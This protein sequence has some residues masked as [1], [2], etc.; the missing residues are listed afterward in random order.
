VVVKIPTQIELHE[1]KFPWVAR[2]PIL[3][4]TIDRCITYLAIL[5]IDSFDCLTDHL[6]L[7]LI[8][9]VILRATPIACLQKL[10]GCVHARD[11]METKFFAS[12]SNCIVYLKTFFFLPF[13]IDS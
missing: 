3:G 12:K 5:C 2:P 11:I 4:Q 1:V 8:I 7:I 9:F 10:H 13:L 6:L